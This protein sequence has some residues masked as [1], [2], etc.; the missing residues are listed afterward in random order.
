M[1][2]TEV[3][4]GKPDNPK[5]HVRPGRIFIHEYTPQYPDSLMYSQGVFTDRFT[6][7]AKNLGIYRTLD[8]LLGRE[9]IR[10]YTDQRTGE[11]K[12]EVLEP[13]K[14]IIYGVVTACG[15]ECSRNS[16]DANVYQDPNFPLPPGTLA[17]IS[18]AVDH[19]ISPR[20]T[21]FNTWDILE[22]L[23]PGEPRN[24]EIWGLPHE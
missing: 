16:T 1:T 4:R 15:I 12:T 3:K 5:R 19:R 22:Y 13:C 14:K 24:P 9:N 7:D 21:G 18:N 23:L 17:K 2:P 11:T 10:R 8:S 6:P 20:E